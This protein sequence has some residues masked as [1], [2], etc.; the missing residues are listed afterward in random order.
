MT[1]SQGNT[2]TTLTSL[3]SAKKLTHVELVDNALD[4]FT[5]A[6]EQMNSAID[7]IQAQIDDEE[8]EIAIRQGKILGANASKD[9]LSRVLDRVKALTA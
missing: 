1:T 6:E 7:Q 5:K 4:A 3:F 8:K 9:R 2:V